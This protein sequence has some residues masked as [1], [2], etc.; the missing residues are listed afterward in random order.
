MGHINFLSFYYYLLYIFLLTM[1]CTCF[2]IL[3]VMMMLIF[4][5]FLSLI[6]KMSGKS[7]CIL[8]ENGV[9]DL[10]SQNLQHSINVQVSSYRYL[11]IVEQIFDDNSHNTIRPDLYNVLQENQIHHY[12][13][14]LTL[15]NNT[16][17]QVIFV[18]TS[19][20]TSYLRLSDGKHVSPVV[21]LVKKDG[22][23]GFGVG[24]VLTI[25]DVRELQMCRGS[26]NFIWIRMWNE[27][28]SHFN[29]CL[30]D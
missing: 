9:L 5:F 16:P 15:A 29:S 8:T 30:L 26:I 10:Y 28:F 7:K 3:Y 2:C 6:G 27:C 14:K 23:L 18:S 22:K 4:F 20:V 17:F 21:L 12:H 24:A 25:H 1:K 19:D 13:L 11:C